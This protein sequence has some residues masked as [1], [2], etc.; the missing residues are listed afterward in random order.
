MRES[1]EEVIAH[2]SEQ[3]KRTEALIRD[4]ID[5]HPDLKR[6][7][8]LLDSIPGIGE[9]TAAALLAEVTDFSQYR[10]ARQVAA[11]AGLVPRERQ[12]GSQ[13]QRTGR[14]SQRSATLGFAKRSPFRPSQR[15]VVVHTFKRGPRAYAKEARAR[16]RSSV[17]RCGS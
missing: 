14:G 3:I 16:W 17:R 7:R 9:T 8:E 12:S 6:Q 2:L 13:C 4:Q 1:V 11:F 15:C 5:H 10:S